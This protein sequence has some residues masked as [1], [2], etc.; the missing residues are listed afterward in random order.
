MIL[1]SFLPRIVIGLAVAI[2]H[3]GI[4]CGDQLGNR[5]AFS[6]YVMEIDVFK[7]QDEPRVMSR[8]HLT[9]IVDKLKSP[10]PNHIRGFVNWSWQYFNLHH[11]TFS[12]YTRSQ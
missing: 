9:L 5:A 1:S 6:P 12:V 2:A 7:P 3:H 4:R 8:N 11:F 10:M